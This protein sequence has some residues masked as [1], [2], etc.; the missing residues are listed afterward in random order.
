MMLS[1]RMAK[2]V[3]LG[4]TASLLLSCAMM[5]RDDSDAGTNP[6]TGAGTSPE[7]GDGTSPETGDGMNPETGDGTGP[8]T[9]GDNR[10]VCTS[11]EFLE[12]RQYISE[13]GSQGIPFPLL[14]HSFCTHQDRDLVRYSFE[15][16]DA[17]KTVH[18]VFALEFSAFEMTPDGAAEAIYERSTFQAITDFAVGNAL[19]KWL[20]CRE[21]IR[22]KEEFAID[23]CTEVDG[24]IRHVGAGE[25]GGQPEELFPCGINV[26][27]DGVRDYEGDEVPESVYAGERMSLTGGAM[28]GDPQRLKTDSRIAGVYVPAMFFD[29]LTFATE[30]PPCGG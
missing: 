1:K 19:S 24:G 20:S 18:A 9:G 5:D 3:L 12:N 8:G 29:A 23:Q 7:T 30:L 4:C 21:M 6:E 13:G 27:P 15:L 25:P 11:S 14:R 26:G 2:S 10:P 28:K 17:R 16:S 22:S